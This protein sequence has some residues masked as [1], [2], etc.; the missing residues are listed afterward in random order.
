MKFYKHCY[1]SLFTIVFTILDMTQNV[2][3]TDCDTFSKMIGHMGKTSSG[4]SY[5]TFTDCCEVGGV[6]CDANKNIVE[7]SFDTFSGYGGN[8][9]GFYEEL[10]NLKSLTSLEIVDCKI[11]GY[12]QDAKTLPK[13]IGNIKNLKTLIIRDNYLDFLGSNIP[14]EIG[15]LINLEKLNLK[16]NDFT[17]AIPYEFK[18]LQNLE[19]IN[20]FG[21]TN[22]KGYVP[23][24]PKLKIC[25]YGVSGL[26]RLPDTCVLIIF[27]SLAIFICVKCVNKPNY[28][29]KMHLEQGNS[30]N[31]AS[32]VKPS[33]PNTNDH[34]SISTDEVPLNSNYI[35]PNVLPP[36]SNYIV[37]N[38]LPPNSN[39][40]TPNVLPPNSNYIPSNEL[41]SNSNYNP[42][43]EPPPAY[44]FITGNQNDTPSPESSSSNTPLKNKYSNYALMNTSK[45]TSYVPPAI[46]IDAQP[47]VSVGYAPPTRYTQYTTYTSPGKSV[48]EVGYSNNKR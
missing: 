33:S 6:T 10:Q 16:S 17:E 29:S 24:L 35:V 47:T 27:T 26:C 46:L 18:N 4:G 23:P 11:G 9:N 36:N 48:P 31:I 45:N 44:S 20:L 40:I 34:T 14:E 22:L 43:D 39:Y 41:P 7:L 19:E 32:N 37:P 42:S 25:D 5:V 1:L 28:D 12:T 13:S 15:N 30:I 8:I 21:N 38:V 2:L 3:A